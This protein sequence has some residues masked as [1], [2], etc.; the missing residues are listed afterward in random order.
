MFQRVVPV[1]MGILALPHV[2]KARRKLMDIRVLMEI[3]AVLHHRANI[4]A[5]AIVRAVQWNS[6]NSLAEADSSAASRKIVR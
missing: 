1:K 5:T 2:Q 3:N 4:A 6:R